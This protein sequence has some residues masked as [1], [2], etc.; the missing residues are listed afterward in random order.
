MQNNTNLSFRGQLAHET[1]L[2]FCRKHWVVLF[3]HIIGLVLFGVLVLGTFI[4]LPKATLYSFISSYAYRIV[5]LV[6]VG[7]STYY[8]HKIFVNIL[9]YFF[10]LL[11]V[12]NYRVVGIDKT[13]FFNDL[14][15]TI[16][17]S[18][19][20]DSVMHK[21]GF[22]QSML[23]YGEVHIML[24]AVSTRKVFSYIPNPDYHFRKINKTKREYIMGRQTQKLQMERDVGGLTVDKNWI[25]M[26]L[27]EGEK[28][29]I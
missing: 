17:L 9:N 6:L 13:V 19:I 28:D 22:L 26:P 11:I 14:R 2:S 25:E 1:V 27:R 10:R 29:M 16:D 18:Q 23:N 5:S 4:L 20:Q 24:S 7:F 15:D 21:T 3:P 12:T 8:L